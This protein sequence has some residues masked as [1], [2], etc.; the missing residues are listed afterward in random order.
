MIDL[1]RVLGSD[2]IFEIINFLK[3]NPD[4][5]A[6]F[7]ASSLNI[8]VV[9]V[10]RVLETM[11]KYGF[12]SAKE[13][14]GVGRPSKTFSYIGGEFKV[15]IDD[16]FSGYDLKDRLV[17]ETGKPEVSFSYNVDREYVNA[18]L[19]GGKRGKKIKLD[20]KTGRF[21][22]LVPPPDSRGE[23][24]ESISSKAGLALPDA[25]KFCLD[26]QELEILEVI[27]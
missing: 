25:I 11:G 18:I 14:G 7:I 23:T 15:N 16:L 22:W 3:K 4:Q 17:R 8:H 26:M 27:Q 20:P 9:T 21:L 13:K 6:S 10:Q 12:V 1:I 2:H 5:N 24:I 19:V